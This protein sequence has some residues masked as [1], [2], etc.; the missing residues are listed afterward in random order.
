MLE[1]LEAIE[2]NFQNIKDNNDIFRFDAEYF[3]KKP[4]K[5]LSEIRDKKYF[6]IIDEFDV[7]KLAG[8]FFLSF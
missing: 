8:L 4:L 6:K 1:G 7:S 5:L 3:R 2:F